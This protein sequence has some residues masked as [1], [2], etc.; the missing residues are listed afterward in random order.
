MH[1]GIEHPFGGHSVW[2][3]L[4][5]GAVAGATAAWVMNQFQAGS[6][7]LQQKLQPQQQQ[8]DSGSSGDDA[9]VKTARAISESVG[10]ELTER[11]KK[12]A[13]PLVHYAF[14][15]L[16]GA[17]YGLV[18]EVQP[19]VRVGFGS[20]FGATLWLVADEIMVPALRLGAKPNEVSVKVHANA[21][22][23]HLVYGATAEAVRHG[24]YAAL[25]HD[26]RESAD[27]VNE[28]ARESWPVKYVLRK[29]A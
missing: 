29:S 9:T 20:A 18:A 5:A 28:Y 8:Q 24:V 6:Q 3:G 12:V 22:A 19:Q 2:K 27:D 15:T 13:G 14:G 26:W 21:L 25:D 7:K 23:A 17:L 1:H 10:H 16:M 4:V 11:E